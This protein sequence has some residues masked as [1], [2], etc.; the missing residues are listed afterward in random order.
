MPTSLQSAKGLRGHSRVSIRNRCCPAQCRDQTGG[1]SN[2]ALSRFSLGVQV[3]CHGCRISLPMIETALAP[4]KQRG[5]RSIQ[6]SSSAKKRSVSVF[7]LPTLSWVTGLSFHPF[8][9]S[10]MR[11]L[12]PQSAISSTS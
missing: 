9:R 5:R 7:A 6:S 8:R 12:G 4:E 3:E 10:R 11:S 1:G 2:E